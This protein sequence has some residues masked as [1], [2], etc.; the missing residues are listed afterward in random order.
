VVVVQNEE[1][2]TCSRHNLGVRVL[3]TVPNSVDCFVIVP[4]VAFVKL[5]HHI[6]RT[7]GRVLIRVLKEAKDKVLQFLVDNM[8]FAILVQLLQ[9]RNDNTVQVL[10]QRLIFTLEK[11][12]EHGENGGCGNVVFISHNFEACD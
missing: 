6:K 12:Q 9:I 10:P 3:D 8:I 7:S 11:L 2:F 4:N 1:E 5:N